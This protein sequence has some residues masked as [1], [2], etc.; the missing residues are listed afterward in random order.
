MSFI[1]LYKL[2]DILKQYKPNIIIYIYT[3]FIL[4][5]SMAIKFDEAWRLINVKMALHKLLH[6]I[7]LQ[8]NSI[9]EGL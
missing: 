1:K 4:S 6:L 9:P 7:T 5:S 2:K 3:Q 8:L